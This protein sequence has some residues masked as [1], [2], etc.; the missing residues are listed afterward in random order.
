[1]EVSGL[2]LQSVCTLQAQIL[3]QQDT[4]APDSIETPAPDTEVPE[5]PPTPTEPAGQEGEDEGKAMGVLRK[6]QED[7]FKGVSGVRL[8]INFHEEITALESQQL[9]TVAQENI[10]VVVK[11]VEDSFPKLLESEGSM[12]EQNSVIGGFQEKFV[13]SVNELMQRFTAGDEL[14][15]EGLIFGLELAFDELFGSLTGVLSATITE[16]PGEGPVTGDVVAE[17]IVAVNPLGDEEDPEPEPSQTSGFNFEEF[18][19]ELRDNFNNAM[20]HF[21]KALE[22]VQVL[23][24]LS[25]PK[26]NGVAFDK[27]LAIYND[28]RS[29]DIVSDNSEQFE[30]MA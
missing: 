9:Q 17:E 6:L 5:V 1:M 26:G 14:S 16:T 22:D 12:G 4:D 30:A 15:T 7:H 18:L 2:S 8:R 13:G 24:E 19:N 23:P 3:D 29:S 28:L 25:E 10:G 21:K 20:E 11:S 27:F